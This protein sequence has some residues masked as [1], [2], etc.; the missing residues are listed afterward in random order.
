M[1]LR[2]R[3]SR[4]EDVDPELRAHLEAEAEEQRASGLPARE[5]S[6]LESAPRAFKTL[7]SNFGTFSS[8]DTQPLPGL[9]I[10]KSMPANMS[11]EAWSRMPLA[12]QPTGNWATAPSCKRRSTT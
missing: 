5:A 2:R 8:W 9:R 1:R 11:S 10:W 7:V 4:E 3:K 6:S 12:Q